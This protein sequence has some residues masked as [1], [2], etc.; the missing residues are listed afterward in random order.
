[1]SEHVVKL[2]FHQIWLFIGWCMV[3]FVIYYSLE[4]GGAPGFNLF[5]NDKLIHMLSYF[6]LMSWFLQLYKKRM[7]RWLIAIGLVCLG[8][9]LEF[10]QGIGGVRMFEVADMM[11]NATGV[12]L[13]W[14]FAL[15]G[16]D[17]VLSWF[18]ARYLVES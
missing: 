10:L 18:E 11:A 2:Q 14:L 9:A 5:F 3:A 12:V 17:K 6:G 13:G 15:L 1:M 16:L 7:S 4:T 8:I